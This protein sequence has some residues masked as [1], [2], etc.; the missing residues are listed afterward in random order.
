MS[1]ELNPLENAFRAAF[2]NRSMPPPPDAPNLGVPFRKILQDMNAK[3]NEQTRR[4]ANE[5]RH[6]L[7]VL[8]P[9]QWQT[10]EQM[11]I[12]D[13]ASEF[14]AACNCRLTHHETMPSIEGWTLSG[15]CRRTPLTG[16]GSG[17]NSPRSISEFTVPKTT[18][19]NRIPFPES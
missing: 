12:D 1:T 16:T 8:T 14:L 5:M 18:T 7:F 13:R 17:W 4:I 6:G 11:D 3:T 2:A 10:L 9:G 15:P 19:P